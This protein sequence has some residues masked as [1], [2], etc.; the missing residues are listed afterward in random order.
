MAKK[1]RNL[2][3]PATLRQRHSL[4]PQRRLAKNELFKTHDF[5][6]SNDPVQVKYE[7]LRKVSVEGRS[8]TEA[9]AEFG[10]SRQ[11]FY[12]AQAAFQRKGLL[13]LCPEERGRGRTKKLNAEIIE[14]IQAIETEGSAL[15]GAA[16]A[17]RLRRERGLRVDPRRIQRAL[18]QRQNEAISA[19]AETEL[20]RMPSEEL[21]AH[22]EELRAQA[23]AGYGRGQGLTLFLREGMQAWAIACSE[24]R[25]CAD[26]RGGTLSLP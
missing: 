23:L 10:L 1:T 12:T 7:M 13:G 5:F 2:C 9:A 11:S 19:D 24:Y 3:K 16:L 14:F 20:A 26:D 15:W 18:A 22:Y 6:N 25:C 4:S 8:V 21:I 17:E